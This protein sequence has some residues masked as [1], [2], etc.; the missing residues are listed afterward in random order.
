MAQEVSEYA[1]IPKS[2]HVSGHYAFYS[3]CN[4]EQR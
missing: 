2:V 3:L 1:W 4:Q